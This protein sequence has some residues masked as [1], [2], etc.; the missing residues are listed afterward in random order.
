MTKIR[1]FFSRFI[2]R[3]QQ[4][5]VRA[6]L[7]ENARILLVKPVGD[8]QWY[9]PGGKV[10]NLESPLRA[11]RRC[12]RDYCGMSLTKEPELLGF[13]HD[14]GKTRDDY[15]SV[16]LCHHFDGFAQVQ[17][18]DHDLEKVAWFELEN[19]PGTLTTGSHRRI[20]EFLKSKST[21]DKW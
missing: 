19:L 17:P 1:A 2:P 11:L 7:I 21:S 8:R 20:G 6:I 14:E 12:L 4:L 16:Y 9:L 13:Y 15:I 5:D 10:K 18:D 3:S